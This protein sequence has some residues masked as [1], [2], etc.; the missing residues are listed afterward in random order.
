MPDPASFLPQS[1]HRWLTR[2]ITQ[3]SI[4]DH[5]ELRRILSRAQIDG[6]IDSG[7]AQIMSAALEVS[8]KTVQ[9]IMVPRPS[10]IAIDIQSAPEE[11]LHIISSTGH[12]RYPVIQSS[13][14]NIQGILRVKGLFV[15]LL[16]N[17]RPLEIK[18]LLHKALHVPETQPLSVLLRELREGRQHMAIVQDEYGEISGLV[19][20]EDV[21][22]EI[23]G[24]INDAPEPSNEI[25]V[26][27]INPKTYVL[28]ALMP[29][30]IFNDKFNQ[31]YNAAQYGT[32]GGMIMHHFGH[33]PQV[34]ETTTINGFNFSILRSDQRQI[35][36]LKMTVK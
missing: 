16:Q 22:E 7:V 11:W 34:G 9:E 32:V 8:N 6:I 13:F 23:V 27:Q 3:R 30:Q 4:K 2:H 17:I 24:E 33:I 31:S 19:T 21:V 15:Q 35:H 26:R 29:I 14:N 25:Y 12:S 20:I 10:V 1:F 28:Q 5:P 18:D 36:L